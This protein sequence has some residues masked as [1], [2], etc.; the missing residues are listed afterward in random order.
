MAIKSRGIMMKAVRRIILLVIVIGI[1]LVI[2]LLFVWIFESITGTPWAWERRSIYTK[3]LGNSIIGN[4][5]AYH[6]LYSKYPVSLDDLVP[7]F[8]NS[9]PQPTLG[10]R[11]WKYEPYPDDDSFMLQFE[12]GGGYPY[13]RYSSTDNAWYCDT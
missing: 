7:E 5:K 9:I 6:K 4:L 11:K 1:V 3:E 10:T 13:C 2:P 8:M 12:A